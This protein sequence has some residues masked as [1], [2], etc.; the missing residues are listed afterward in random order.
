MNTLDLQKIMNILLDRL[1]KSKINWCFGGSINLVLQGIDFKFTDID[2]TTDKEGAYEIEKLFKE[3]VK[4]PVA[5]S[6]TDMFSSYHGA[7]EINN[8]KIDIM[9]EFKVKE[10]SIWLPIYKERLENKILIKY[11]G[12]SAFVTPLKDIIIAYKRLNREKDLIKI[13]LIE[14]KLGKSK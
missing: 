10:N 5:F 2:I 1:N 12:K 6:E 7:L 8:T 13:K 3:Y 11:N 4:N 9:G 14:E